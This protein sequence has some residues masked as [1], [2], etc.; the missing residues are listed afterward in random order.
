[1]NK[2]AT[3][4]T[5]LF[6]VDSDV[7]ALR[8]AFKTQLLKWVGN[9]QRFAHEIASCFPEK[10]N[11]YHEP[12]MGSGAVLS[13]LAP[14]KGFASDKYNPLV[15]I[16][17]CLKEDPERLVEW[18]SE[19]W[20]LADKL[21]KKD[22]YQKILDSFN[23]SANGADLLFLCRACYGGVVRFRKADGFMSTPVG[24]HAPIKPE[25][26][27]KRAMEWHERCKN[28]TFNC[29]DYKAA[30]QRAQ[31][32]DLVYCDP[33]YTHSQG[34]LYGGQGF[35]LEELCEIIQ[36][37]KDRG[38][39]VALSIDGTKKS[40]KLNCDLPIPEN[41]FE[42]EIFVNCGRSMLRR[43]QMGGSTLEAEVVSDRLLLT[44]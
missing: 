42:R 21:G 5:E 15:E 10:Y 37:C 4:Q 26:F 16:F 44:Y 3:M 39:Y 17:Q 35:R 20:H 24:V 27:R 7:V 8:P 38:V 18:Y 43:F 34:I 22:G 33:P 29:E 9:K 1:M 19:R 41:L 23:S 30:M 13:T 25:S 2:A 28:I 32:G 36:D 40:G 12:F 11:D 6:D 14:E 31:P